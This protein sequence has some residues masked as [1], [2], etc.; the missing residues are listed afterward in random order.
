MR[1]CSATCTVVGGIRTAEFEERTRQPSTVISNS[2]SQR[3]LNNQSI[4][5]SA[6]QRP[7]FV[8]YSSVNEFCIATMSSSVTKVQQRTLSH[9][10]QLLR[11][12]R[13]NFEVASASS[14]G[15]PVQDVSLFTNFIMEQY[16]NNRSIADRSQLKNLRNHAADVVSY[17]QA[18]KAQQVR[19]MRSSVKSAGVYADAGF[20]SDYSPFGI[21]SPSCCRIC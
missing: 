7:Q 3:Q 12:A 20:A 9:L 8:P 1:S 18:V 17:L 19:V 13:L 11:H 16:R 21:T 5:Q 15:E 4:T 14:S 2:R 10:R 6:L